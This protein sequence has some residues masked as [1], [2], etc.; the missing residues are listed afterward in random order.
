MAERLLFSPEIGKDFMEMPI[1]AKRSEPATSFPPSFEIAL[2]IGINA[3][4]AHAQIPRAEIV[5]QLIS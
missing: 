1:V 5:I 3:L 4:L 2:P